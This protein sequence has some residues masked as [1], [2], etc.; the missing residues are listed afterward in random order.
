M[1]TSPSIL[2]EAL[3]FL[4]KQKHRAIHRVICVG[5]Q[6][7][8]DE[9]EAQIFASGGAM[10]RLRKFLGKP[11]EW[12]TP[13]NGF[14]W[15]SEPTKDSRDLAQAKAMDKRFRKAVLEAQ[16]ES[17]ALGEGEVIACIS[18][19][20]KTMS[21]SL[22]QAM[23]LL[24]RPQDWAF[25]VLLNLPDGFDERTVTKVDKDKT[26]FGFPGDPKFPNLSSV[27]V[28]GF[29]LSLVRLRQFALSYGLDLNKSGLIEG[30]QKGV[31]E[32]TVYPKLTIDIST[33]YAQIS[34]G[35]TN[36]IPF[37]LSPQSMVL[38]AAWCLGNQ[39]MRRQ[40]AGPVFTRV[41]NMCNNLPGRI[42]FDISEMQKTIN[43]WLNIDGG[44][45]AFDPIKSRLAEQLK[46]IDPGCY[47]FGLNAKKPKPMTEIKRLGI[48]ETNEEKMQRIK[49]Y[50]IGFHEIVYI[51]NLIS[52]GA[53]NPPK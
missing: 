3:W 12:L 15:E 13:G 1:G 10:E 11:P 43:F 19:G 8:R 28:D 53:V 34:R 36:S 18:G 45:D 20:R 9:A 31:D 46:E 14:N 17:E 37:R 32:A 35:S 49:P 41:I 2:T 22:H 40:D 50:P 33:L 25:H 48:V 16:K 6:A 21:S 30:I 7:S 23:I 39:P 47:I 29:E 4:E 27:G 38:L 42:P 26:S 24:A 51:N 52:L 44:A 5:T